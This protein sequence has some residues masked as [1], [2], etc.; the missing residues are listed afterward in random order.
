MRAFLRYLA[1]LVILIAI[2]WVV[3]P[4]RLNLAFPRQP[5]PNF[6]KR[7]RTFYITILNKTKPDIVLLGDSTLLDGVD[8]DLLSQLMGKKAASFDVPGSASAFWYILLKNS[9]VPAK[10]H[11]EAV[12]VIFRST[13][14]TAPGYRVHGGYFERLYEFAGPQESVLLERAYLNQMSPLAFWA[15]K[16]FPLYS[17]REKIR[18]KIDA[19]IRYTTPSWLRCDVECTDKSMYA[20]FT[21]AD[22]EPGQLRNAVATAESYLSTP[23]QLDFSSQV[24]KSFLPEMIRLTKEQGIQLIVVRLKNKMTGID[25]S[26]T[27]AGQKYISDLST[28]LD[29]QGVIFLDYGVEPRLTREYFRDDLH[30]NPKGEVVF[31][32]ILAEGLIKVLK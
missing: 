8:P 27:A 31:T 20:V 6:N 26:E 22:L 13:M 7:A 32:H 24:E 14:L 5:G 30:L 18:R 21:S 25:N 23:A 15:E 11:P 4:I 19:A 12:V 2:S 16:Y 1:F 3:I 17:A 9:I 10:H 29:Q 28:Y